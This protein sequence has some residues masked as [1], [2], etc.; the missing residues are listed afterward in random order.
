MMSMLT[1]MG[2]TIEVTEI[3]LS[4]IDAIVEHDGCATG[5]SNVERII[6][7]MGHSAAGEPE[8]KPSEKR[9]EASE[10]EARREIIVRKVLLENIGARLGTKPAGKRAPVAD[11]RYADFSKEV[12][13]SVIGDIIWAI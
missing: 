5:T 4:N 7:F 9:D 1:S 3:A 12:G 11:I 2:Q 10:E 6:D 8:K 13:V